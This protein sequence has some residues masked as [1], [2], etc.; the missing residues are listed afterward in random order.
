MLAVQHQSYSLQTK[1]EYAK[2]FLQ[3]AIDITLFCEIKFE[4]RAVL[5]KISFKFC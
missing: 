3:F 4:A 5:D 2:I 1:E